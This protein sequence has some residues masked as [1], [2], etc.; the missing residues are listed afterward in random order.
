MKALGSKL[1]A[2]DAFASPRASG[3]V[4]LSNKP[5]PAAALAFKNLRRETL[6]GDPVAVEFSTW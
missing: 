2:P 1:L 6:S 5:P 4:R 3:N